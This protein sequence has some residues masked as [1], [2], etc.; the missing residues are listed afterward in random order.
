MCQELLLK[1]LGP[2][3]LAEYFSGNVFEDV[4]YLEPFNIFS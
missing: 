2:Q 4:E 1:T 3:D